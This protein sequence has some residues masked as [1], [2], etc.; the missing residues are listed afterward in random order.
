MAAPGAALARPTVQAQGF[1]AEAPAAA[2]EWVRRAHPEHAE[3]QG[4]AVP[5]VAPQ[6]STPAF[7]FE[8][9][10]KGP[11]QAGNAYENAQPCR[12]C[13]LWRHAGA[14]DWPRTARFVGGSLFLER[15]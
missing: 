13:G 8:G 14:R 1:G 2:R 7:A 5:A 15:G 9:R 11:R 4:Q 10:R 6:H 3:D 12:R